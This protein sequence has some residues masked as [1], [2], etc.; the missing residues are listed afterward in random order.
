M[1]KIS[2]DDDTSNTLTIKRSVISNCNEQFIHS[3]IITI[4]FYHLLSSSV[5]SPLTMIPHN[6]SALSDGM[7]KNHDDDNNSDS[8]DN[9]RDDG[10][11]DDDDDDDDNDDSE[12]TAIYQGHYTHDIVV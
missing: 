3:L 2:S 5:T 4:I 8:D 10:D 11:Y 6:G 7:S 1:L 12:G 9:D